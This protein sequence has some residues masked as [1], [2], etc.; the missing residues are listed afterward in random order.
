[1]SKPE[2]IAAYVSGRIGRRDFVR[3][4]TALGVSA[5]AAAAYA[6][7]LAPGAEAAGLGHDRAGLRMRAQAEYT[8]GDFGDVS[9]IIQLLLQI[10][11]L[12][13]GILNGG[14]K[15]AMAVPLRAQSGDKLAQDD[16]DQLNTLHTQ[17]L[18][19]RD[20]LRTLLD[21]VGGKDTSKVPDLTYDVPKDSLLDLQSALEANLGVYAA[22]IPQ[23]KVQKTVATLTAIGLVGGRHA[24]FVSRLLGD[25]AFPRTFQ[26]AATPEE[27]DGILTG[28]AG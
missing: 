2:L 23:I 10:V 3:Y 16:L 22:V 8:G 24:A 25:P 6:Q 20:A 5:T 21:E 18:S 28:L 27:T 15:N 26:K 17:L 11:A 9:S 7:T 13:E 14:L 4:L 19:H 1:M 12:L